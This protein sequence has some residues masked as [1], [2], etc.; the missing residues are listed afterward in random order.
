VAAV[1]SADGRL[2]IRRDD[3]LLNATSNERERRARR[4]LLRE[5]A[6][7][8]VGRDELQRAVDE[9]RLALLPA[10]MVL[11][12]R[13][14]FGDAA[15]R[16]AGL[17]P[18]ELHDW[19]RASGLREDDG[20][21][22][23]DLAAAR[24]LGHILDA[25][26]PE[27]ALL[28]VARVAGQGMAATA[29]AMVRITGETYLR[30]GDTEYDLGARYALVA[31]DLVPHLGP[32]LEHQLRLHLLEA[33]RHET[34][35]RDEL[36]TGRLAASRGVTV[37]FADLVGF[38]RMGARV[39]A[40]EVG[41]VAGRLYELTTE[42]S[43][44]PVTLVKTVGDAVMLVSPEAE[45]LVRQ[46]LELVRRADA[47]GADFPQLRVGVALG[48]AVAVGGD[49]YGHAVN[50]ASRITALA[51]PGTVLATTDVREKARDGIS[52]TRALPRRIKGVSGPVFLTR[53]RARAAG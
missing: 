30:P 45:P 13:R 14:R 38:T 26:V 42:I 16:R 53:A 49:W 48:P 28:E 27:D 44:A 10:E 51:R 8:G 7:S 21:S 46:L 22:A 31:Q 12:G 19:L 3:P 25:G 37:A 52:W 15:L 9:S 23:G 33:L 18:D 11:T 24:A 20:K 35:G 39:D 6:A 2:V 5:L 29:R 17:T 40:D 34:I 41:R 36:T 43:E 4:R 47:E 32:L 1:A 50:L